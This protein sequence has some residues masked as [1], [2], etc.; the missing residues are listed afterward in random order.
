[1][2]YNAQSRLMPVRKSNTAAAK[3]ETICDE[4]GM[5]ATATKAVS[6]LLALLQGDHLAV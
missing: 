3:G 6:L 4:S 2:Q 5:E 1:M